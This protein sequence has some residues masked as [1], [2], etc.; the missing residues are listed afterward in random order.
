VEGGAIGRFVWL[1]DIHIDNGVEDIATKLTNLVTYIATL[2]PPIDFVLFSGD[3]AANGAVEAHYID[4]VA[5]LAGLAIPLYCVPGNHDQQPGEVFTNYDLHIAEER[6]VLVSGGVTF[7]GFLTLNST[8]GGSF[9]AKISA[10]ELVW[11]EAQ[12]IAADPTKPIVLIS[13][14]GI[15]DYRNGGM[16]INQSEGGAALAAL[17]STYGVR[18]HISGHVHASPFDAV[19]YYGNLFS[20]AS[21]SF[22]GNPGAVSPY[23]N[24]VFSICNI[25][26]DRI[27]VDARDAVTHVAIPPLG[28]PSYNLVRINLR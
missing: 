11:I 20:V 26:N 22:W 1:S 19:Y 25:F 7:I 9:H 8:T 10:A 16:C 13:H 28:V 5:A 14:H 24:G 15:G 3:I 6:F 27:E 12:L 21:S 23:D 18:A 17:C 4:L 2:D